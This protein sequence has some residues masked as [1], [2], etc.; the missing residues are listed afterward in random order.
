MRPDA[1]PPQEPFSAL[2]ARNHDTVM[3]LAEAV[4]TVEW[5]WGNNPYQSVA[6]YPAPQPRGDVLALIHGG[7]WTNGYKEWMA[8]MAPALTARGITVASLGYR[9]APAHVWPACFD[10]VADGLASLAGRVAAQGA[11]PGRLFVSGHSAGGHLA[12]LLAL[13]RDWQGP[14]GLPADAVKGALPISGTYVLGPE[15][16][17]AVRPRFLGDPAL[18][19]EAPASP[20]THVA[21]GAPPFL[22][23]WGARDFP[24]LIA[25]AQRF[26]GALAGAGIACT[27]L[28]LADADHLGAC[29]DA[30]Q[31]DGPWARAADDFLRST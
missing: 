28:E 22:L 6:L 17:F 7:G 4:P 11:D 23:A 24:H 18:A 30:G 20:L 14:R 25:Q 3:A 19:N 8:F 15:S 5:Q 31:P 29:L 13:R 27:T 2:G 1:Y 10:D 12:S 9:L 26:A 16:G 21:P